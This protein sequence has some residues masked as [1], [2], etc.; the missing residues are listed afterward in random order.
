MKNSVKNNISKKKEYLYVILFQ[1][2][3]IQIQN[4]KIVNKTKKNDKESKV[5]L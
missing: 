2:I 3:I 4:K 1:L 5:I